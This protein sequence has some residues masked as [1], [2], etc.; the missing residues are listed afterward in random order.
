MTRYRKYKSEYELEYVTSYRGRG[1]YRRLWKFAGQSILEEDVRPRLRMWDWRHIQG[2][3]QRCKDYRDRYKDKLLGTQSRQNEERLEELEKILDAFNININ[4]EMAERLV[5]IKKKHEA[6]SGSGWFSGWW[7]GKKR[8]EDGEG[9]SNL[10]S[11][12]QSLTGDEKKALYDAIDYHEEAE[13]GTLEYPKSFVKFRVGFQLSRFSITVQDDNIVTT[14]SSVLCLMLENVDLDIS[15]R[16][17]A[18]NLKIDITMGNLTVTGLK[19]ASRSS[20]K[21]VSTVKKE[22]SDSKL[23]KFSLEINPP[24]N[25][26]RED[27]NNDQGSLYDR[28]LSLITSPLEIIYDTKTIF[29]LID[30]FKSPEEINVDYIQEAA[31][32]GIKEYKDVKMSQLGW[33]YARDN[34]VFFKV[35]ISLESSYFIFPK[36]GEYYE[37]CPAL[38]ANLGSVFV[39]SKEVTQGMINSKK[40]GIL[41]MNEEVITNWQEQAYDQ[42]SIQLMNMVLMMMRE[43]EDWRTEMNNRD[44]KLFMLR[45]IDMEVTLKMCL[46]QND[47]DFPVYKLSGFLPSGIAVNIEERRLLTLAEVAQ[48][49]LDPEEDMKYEVAPVRR[50]ESVSSFHSAVSSIETVNSSLGGFIGRK[51]PTAVP[52]TVQK[53][54]PDDEKVFSSKVTK[55]KVEF[56]IR[57]L[58]LEVEEQEAPLFRF[59]LEDLGASLSV[60]NYNI[61]GDFSIGGCQCHQSKFRMPNGSPVALLS[62]AKQNSTH[63]A[64]RLLSVKIQR[65]EEKSPDWAGVHLAVLASMSSVDLCLHQDAILDLARE[66]TTWVTKLQS[67]ASKLMGPGEEAARKKLSHVGGSLSPAPPRLA[68]HG[69]VRRLSRQ[70]SGGEQPRPAL[71]HKYPRRN[72]QKKEAV[73][74]MIN[75]ELQSVSADLMS[76]KVSFATLKVE[77]LETKLKLSKSKTE[78][79]TSLKNFKVFDRSPGTLYKMIAECTGD[80]VL[81]VSVVMYDLL[82]DT[83]KAAGMPD[84]MVRIGMGQIKFVFLMKFVSDI[85]VFIDPFT[86]MKEFLYEQALDMVDRSARVLEEGY[87]NATRVRLD[88]MLEAPIIVLPVSSKKP[89]TF[90]ANLG[91]LRLQNHHHTTQH[92]AHTISLDTMTVTLTNMK[93]SRSKI[94]EDTSDNSTV[95]SCE[96]IKPIDFELE[97]TRNMDGAIKEE[98]I[99]EIQ[100]KGTL[101]EIQVEL[102]KDDY[103]ALIAMV[104]E[105]FQERG[106]MEPVNKSASMPKKGLHLPLDKKHGG[107]R[108]SSQLSISS[109]TSRKSLDVITQGKSPKAKLA[110]F[111][112]TFK[113]ARMKIFKDKTD[114]TKIQT[115]RDAKKRLGQLLINTLTVTGNYRVSGA[116]KADA[117]LND[118]VLED[119]RQ[120]TGSRIKRLLEA[121]KVGERKESDMIQ[122]Q[123]TKD[124]HGQENVVVH[125]NSFVVVASVSYLLEISYFFIPEDMPEW[126]EAGSGGQ[127]LPSVTVQDE[128]DLDTEHLVRTILVKMEEPD[129]VLVNNI[130]DINTDAIMLNAE[131]TINM[132]QQTERMSFVLTVDRFYLNN[133]HCEASS[134]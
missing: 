110:E 54:K 17:A 108:Y 27:L 57:R 102:S 52:S 120:V 23:L 124:D 46:I 107:T 20:P 2:H 63:Q 133:K 126:M 72:K 84:I 83:D 123:Y 61:Q 132:T 39:K 60:K 78:I 81:D 89:F 38:I 114:L 65:L 28:N 44:S 53:P 50:A 51:P 16:P 26:Y 48:D 33:E 103:N 49:I 106:I 130:E 113:G 117:N 43:G 88:I 40:V 21:L 115:S 30:V 10:V 67:K 3:I 37:G 7:S 92:Y 96:I 82:T 11:L 91:N 87:N 14:E 45:P 85:L 101:H 56:S 100:V 70:S 76:S 73:D 109:R 1:L 62:T 93:V 68:R 35:D 99:P 32:D 119:N 134:W 55:L 105:N 97:V 29:A 12:G 111:D 9:E 59:Q 131:L 31:M 129:I 94:A 69:V 18:S 34:H 75:A 25:P 104:I 71:L 22:T 24:E 118:V 79:E 6:E 19:T 125:I 98:D 77:N 4:R 5:D 122:V 116:L 64:E 80:Q 58:L 95:G 74:L 127:A 90:E 42:F 112:I 121:K 128:A 13:E 15:Q 36:R 47:P 8:E 66:A 86:N 41:N